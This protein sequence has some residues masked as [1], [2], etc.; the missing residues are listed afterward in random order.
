MKQIYKVLCDDP[1]GSL[2]GHWIV[3]LRSGPSCVLCAH[4]F[5]KNVPNAE[6]ACMLQTDLLAS[7][8]LSSSIFATKL[9]TFGDTIGDTFGDT[10]SV[11]TTQGFDALD[12]LFNMDQRS[13]HGSIQGAGGLD[14]HDL[15][16]AASQ[17]QPGGWRR[18]SLHIA[19]HKVYHGIDV[20]EWLEMRHRCR[21]CKS[22]CTSCVG[23]C[24]LWF[25]VRLDIC[26]RFLTDSARY[27]VWGPCCFE[28]LATYCMLISGKRFRWN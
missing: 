26:A 4:G 12:S 16:F 8:D 24:R 23:S 28:V 27:S 5:P 7:Q 1:L 9:D 10:S 25:G 21:S 3:C 11:L 15:S 22:R 13:P 18:A 19:K 2:K 6:P 20:S 17:L 14:A